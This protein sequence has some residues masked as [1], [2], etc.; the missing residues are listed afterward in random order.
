MR[1]N[2]DHDHA[3]PEILMAAMC[4]YC[5]VIG[6]VL[7]YII[8]GIYFM[9]TDRYICTDTPEKDML[10]LYAILVLTLPVGFQYLLSC[11]VHQDAVFTRLTAT[12]AVVFS[13][14]VYGAIVLFGNNVCDA[15]I[16]SGGL[17]IWVQFQF[18]LSLFCFAVLVYVIANPS[19]L[20]SLDMTADN[21]TEPL[22][23]SQQQT[24]ENK[25][26]EGD[27]ID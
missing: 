12:G 8:A 11:T 5:L 2:V 10:W 13:F 20:D 24:E 19:A 27:G 9:V 17:Y 22:I 18:A 14:I 4:C 25:T 7:A 6:G 16:G 26:Y 3:A 21:K 15:Q 23:S 1:N